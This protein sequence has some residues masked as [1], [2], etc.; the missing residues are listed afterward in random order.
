MEW[1]TITGA[2]R[3][4]A[5]WPNGRGI[6]RDYLR[7]TGPD[8]G[9]VWLVTV[10]ELTQDAPFSL[11]PYERVFTVASGSAVELTI[12]GAPVVAE[13]LRPVRFS[14]RSAT[15]CRLLGGPARAFNLMHPPGVRADVAVLRD[16]MTGPGE[17]VVFCPDGEARVGALHLVAGDAAHG[18][19]SVAVSGTVLVA[20]L[21]AG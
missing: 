21:V 2:S 10:A 14:G 9:L 3:V 4:A 5:P 11:M 17:H 6:T 20:T 1:T 15:T 13:P 19:G 18:A 12:D 7:R 16:G 8:G